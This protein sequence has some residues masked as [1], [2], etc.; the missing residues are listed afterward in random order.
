MKTKEIKAVAVMQLEGLMSNTAIQ[1][2]GFTSRAAAHR[3]VKSQLIYLHGGTSR[4]IQVE[5]GILKNQILSRVTT[6]C[7][8]CWGIVVDAC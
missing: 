6:S 3:W 8:P 2:Q 1:A 7:G 4:D 5:I